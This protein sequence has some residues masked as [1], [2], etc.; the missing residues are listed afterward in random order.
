[1]GMRVVGSGVRGWASSWVFFFFFF[2]PLLLACPLSPAATQLGLV[3]RQT[4]VSV[5][6]IVLA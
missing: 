1:M 4:C 5:A 3:V 6:V 2:S